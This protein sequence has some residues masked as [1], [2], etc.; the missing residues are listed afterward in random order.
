MS[1]TKVIIANIFNK[2]DICKNRKNKCNIKNL[3]VK[4]MNLMKESNND[5]KNFSNYILFYC[6]IKKCCLCL[7]ESWNE[8]VY[9]SNKYRMDLINNDYI[10][11]RCNTNEP[12]YYNIN[13]QC[14]QLLTPVTIYTSINYLNNPYEYINDYSNVVDTFIG[15]RKYANRY[16]IYK[17]NQEI[18]LIDD[19]DYPTASDDIVINKLNINTDLDK[20]F[21]KIENHN[22]KKSDYELY[23]K[24]YE[25][26]VKLYDLE[27]Y[28]AA[29]HKLL[30]NNNIFKI[31]ERRLSSEPPT[32]KLCEIR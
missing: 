19:E 22:I 6:K 13:R 8:I 23:N 1:I 12:H 30:I 16:K 3:L 4:L 21:Y 18:N 25:W 11:C 9:E 28:Q 14:C 31:K 10:Y 5:I 15:C 26:D 24:S 17:N 20:E 29:S 2:I 27:L 7:L 32:K